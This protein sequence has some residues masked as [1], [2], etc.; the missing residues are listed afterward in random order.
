M[1]EFLIRNEDAVKEIFPP[2][3]TDEAYGGSAFLTFLSVTGDIIP[4]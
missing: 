4:A 3:E 2:Q 1:D